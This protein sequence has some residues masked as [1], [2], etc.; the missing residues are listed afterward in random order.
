MGAQKEK[1]GLVVDSGWSWSQIIQGTGHFWWE[2][3]RATDEDIAALEER[4]FQVITFSSTKVSQARA[5]L[6]SALV[7]RILGWGFPLE[8]I[9]KELKLYWGLKGYLSVS[10]LF[11]GILLFWLQFEE[12]DQLLMNGPWFLARQLLALKK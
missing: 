8:F 4:F 10:S 6:K 3:S 9:Q 11:E 1:E 12:K 2:S 5:K 7:G